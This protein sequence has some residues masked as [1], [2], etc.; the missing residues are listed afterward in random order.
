[1][2]CELKSGVNT[3]EKYLEIILSFDPVKHKNPLLMNN[4]QS[5]PILEHDIKSNIS[6]R[7]LIC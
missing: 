5:Q 3:C 6:N 4:S 1:M 7:A 2:V